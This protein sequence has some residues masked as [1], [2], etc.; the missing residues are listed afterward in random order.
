MVTTEAAA[1]AYTPAATSVAFAL[2]RL[3]IATATE[4]VVSLLFTVYG[5]SAI[6]EPVR[7]L[8]VAV[9]VTVSPAVIV[10]PTVIVAGVA[11]ATPGSAAVAAVSVP[12]VTRTP[13]ACNE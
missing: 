9:G 7:V 5:P 4:A 12:S 2:M 11:L 8:D 1:E 13:Q 10:P 6:G 3:A